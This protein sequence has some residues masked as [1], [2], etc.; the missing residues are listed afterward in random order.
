MSL[1]TGALV[2]YKTKCAVIDAISDGKIDIRV[3]DGSRK[4]V[5]PKDVDFL[6]PG[7]AGCLP[8]PELPPPDF[9]ELIELT[10]GESLPFAEFCELAYGSYSAAA[11]WNAYLNL[12]DGTYFRGS[13]ENGVTP[14]SAEEIA[15][16]C[17]AQEAKAQ[18]AQAREDLLN[19]IRN[20]AVTEA[21][22]P[23]LR[24]IEQV[25]LGRAESS[26]L[27]R[28]LSIAPEPVNAHKLLCKLGYW[29]SFVNPWPS[30]YGIELDDPALLLPELPAEERI[31]LTAMTAFA[32][33]DADSHDPDDAISFADGMLYVHIAD[34]GALVPPESELDF[35]A[36]HRGANLYLPEKISHML[37]VEIT[38]KLGLGLN[39]ISPALTFVLKIHENGEPELVKFMPSLVKVERLS[40]D[41]AGALMG[42]SPLADIAPLLERFRKFREDNGAL[43][44]DLPEVKVKV[45][46]KQVIITPIYLL[47]VR[48]LVA[49]SML[50]TGA[51]LGKWAETNG[52]PMPFAIQPEPENT[53]HARTMSGMFACRKGCAPSTVSTSAGKHS[54]LGLE[55]YIRVTSPL[56]RYSDLLA[57]QQLRRFLKGEE[58]LSVEHMED[59][60]AVSERSGFERRKLERQ[61]NEFWKLVYLSMNKEWQGE[62]VMVNKEDDR[63]TFLI[64]E[65]AYE[66]KSRF[67]GAVQLDDVVKIHVNAADPVTMTG[68]FMIDK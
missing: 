10:D 44:I 28:D 26:R 63:L 35:E 51:A 6:H 67:G 33:D 29:D 3:S 46:D 47:P 22:Y 57:H 39:E 45:R 25:A 19:R 8:P 21:D 49:N 23:A 66:Y 32:I 68:K 20:G 30:R 31:D 42:Q 27:L 14:R 55:P 4:S 48:E 56:R 54:G 16:A 17:A 61:S 58:L 11:A 59:R 43:F 65:L 52:I 40:Y 18:A 53:E 38:E 60:I 1:K 37:P 12:C 36:E 9:Q 64:P 50:A 41:E 24:E 5:R 34:A 15:A 13:P 2:I 62:A 7:P